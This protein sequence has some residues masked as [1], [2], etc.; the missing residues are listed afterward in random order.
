MGVEK[1]EM[2]L[3]NNLRI[4]KFRKQLGDPIVQKEW[5]RQ[6]GGWGVENSVVVTVNDRH[7][8]EI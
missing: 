4:F 1:V 7:L 6:T 8:P 5:K 3:K 2:R